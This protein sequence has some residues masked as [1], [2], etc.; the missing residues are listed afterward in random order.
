MNA[1]WTVTA[2]F[3]LSKKC[4]ILYYLTDMGHNERRGG[5]W[6]CLYRREISGYKLQYGTVA[7]VCLSGDRVR[8]GAFPRQVSG[9][10]LRVPQHPGAWV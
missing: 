2:C 5:I 9:T 6:L 8:A 10:H 1:L 7:C 3:F 4:R